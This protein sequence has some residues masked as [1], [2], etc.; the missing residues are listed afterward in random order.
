MLYHKYLLI[1]IIIMLAIWLLLMEYCSLLALFIPR[2]SSI[3][4]L[5]SLM[6]PHWS[7]QSDASN[8][9]WISRSVFSII[10]SLDYFF[11]IRVCTNIALIHAV[12][13]LAMSFSRWLSI[14]CK[15]DFANSIIF[16]KRTRTQFTICHF[17]ADY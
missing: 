8:N 10:L 13:H 14:Y 2:F 9:L 4:Y 1:S 7:I 11:T 3:L 5:I 17:A 12:S 6:C 16:K 15:L